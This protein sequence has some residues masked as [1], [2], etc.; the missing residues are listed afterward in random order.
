[1]KII[2]VKWQVLSTT[3]FKD[4]ILSAIN[5]SQNLLLLQFL[6]FECFLSVLQLCIRRWFLKRWSWERIAYPWYGQLFPFSCYV[7][8]YLCTDAGNNVFLVGCG[9]ITCCHSY[10][11][12]HSN[13]TNSNDHLNVVKRH[14]FLSRVYFHLNNSLLK[15]EFPVYVC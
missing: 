5:I 1:M 14:L 7:I 12:V 6:H 8:A 2:N 9:R 10:C 3:W 13:V 4:L 15:M 11:S